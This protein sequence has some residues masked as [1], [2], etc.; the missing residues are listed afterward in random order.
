[1]MFDILTIIESLETDEQKQTAKEVFGK[2]QYAIY[3]VAYDVLK[4]KQDAE[5]AVMNTAEKMCRNIDLFIDKT[6]NQR[7]VLIFKC[8]QNAAIDIYREKQRKSAEYID[9][10][11]SNYISEDEDGTAFD[12]QGDADVYLQ[13]YDFGVLQ[14]YVI[15]LPLK[16]KEVLLLRFG[17]QLQ[18]K[19]IAE[20]YHTNE[21]TV[22]TWIHR[23]KNALKKLADKDNMGGKNG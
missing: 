15:R 10:I 17:L 14:K 13:D 3:N 19:K 23:A 20:I 16:Y 4:N 11:K 22:A 5:D 2:Y 6:E 8:A 7:K 18:N 12:V 1:M 9:D 21:N